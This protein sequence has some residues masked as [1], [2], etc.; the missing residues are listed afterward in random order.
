MYIKWKPVLKNIRW[1]HEHL[2]MPI[3]GHSIDG[4]LATT[5]KIDVTDLRQLACLMEGMRFYTP[6]L[7]EEAL[8]T[9]TNDFFGLDQMQSGILAFSV[10]QS[11]AAL[12]L[13]LSEHLPPGVLAGRVKQTYVP[14]A[15][16]D[17]A[18]FDWSA[19][20]PS[21]EQV[22]RYEMWQRVLAARST[23]AEATAREQARVTIRE[24]YS[25]ALYAYT[26]MVAGMILLL[27][28]GSLD[29]EEILTETVLRFRDAAIVTMYYSIPQE[30]RALTGTAQSHR[31]T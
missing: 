5:F 2:A 3:S 21:H 6:L 31:Q 10:M 15:P 12:T 7:A 29:P 14:D 8:D 22:E 19:I 25:D 27:L 9:H 30:Y 28:A 17:P 18:S 23:P 16:V 20:T 26:Y 13:K 24:A 11:S 4:L 1:A